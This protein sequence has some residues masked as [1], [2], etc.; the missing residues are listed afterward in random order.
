MKK[1]ILVFIMY[2]ACFSGCFAKGEWNEK[3]PVYDNVSYIQGKNDLGAVDTCVPA[4]LANFL[5]LITG[6]NN[7]SE[8]YMIDNCKYCDFTEENGTVKT[9]FT[10]NEAEVMREVKKYINENPGITYKDYVCR[11]KGC[12][13][14]RKT[15][16]KFNEIMA[17]D[18]VIGAAAFTEIST[19]MI[20]HDNPN[21]I[22]INHVITIAG[23]I[24]EDG[25]LI[26][27]SVVDTGSGY[28]FISAED[29]NLSEKRKVDF[30]WLIDN[31]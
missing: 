11:H 18:G 30:I 23:P 7:Y 6:T 29:F 13:K 8:Q 25:E 21:N 14:A 10:W 17:T 4:A 12:D 2:L 3:Y 31:N 5:N 27:F 28:N 20:W 24:Y 16:E 22:L 1:I 19:G 26:G 15:A 9:L